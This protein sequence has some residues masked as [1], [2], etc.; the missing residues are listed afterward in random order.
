MKTPY[1]AATRWKKQ[2]LDA[3]RRELAVLLRQQEDIELNIA[4]IDA[5]FVAE[6]SH[7]AELPLHNFAGFAT[8]SRAQRTRLEADLT[9]LET[10][11]IALQARI[12]EAFQDFKGL[13]VA[14]ERY[15]DSVRKQRAQKEAEALDEIALQRHLRLVR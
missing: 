9:T 10:Q 13:D 5:S 12:T 8:R 7:M 15:R 3:L 11:V 4:S 6:Q 2:T 14:G 1:D